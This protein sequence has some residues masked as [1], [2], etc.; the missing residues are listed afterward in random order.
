MLQNINGHGIDV[1]LVENF[2]AILIRTN[3]FCR[4]Y[5]QFNLASLIDSNA[6][7]IIQIN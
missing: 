1:I 3:S 7:F 2:A 5:L 4:Y 6:I